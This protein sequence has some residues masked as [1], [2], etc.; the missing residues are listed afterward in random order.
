MKSQVLS[1]LTTEESA[2]AT[3]SAD[4]VLDTSITIALTGDVDD[5]AFQETVRSSILAQVCAG[6]AESCQVEL[7]SVDR[8][9]RA[10]AS[11]GS[12]TWRIVRSLETPPPTSDAPL[13]DDLPLDPTECSDPTDTIA[14]CTAALAAQLASIALA[15]LPASMGASQSGDPIVSGV[16]VVGVLMTLG[17]DQSDISSASKVSAL[18]DGVATSLELA[19]SDVTVEP[20]RVI[21]PPRP[22]PSSPPLPTAPPAPPAEPPPV[23]S[24]PVGGVGFTQYTEGCDPSCV[25]GCLSS[26]WSNMYAPPHADRPGPR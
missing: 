20:V 24:L 12:L 16:R 15:S 21:H 22:P 1:G 18:V 2:S 11:S 13:S 26:K 17:S 8:R 10:L 3:F 4:V 14:S 9:R 19:S 25:D 6:Q 23:P 5:V 7:S